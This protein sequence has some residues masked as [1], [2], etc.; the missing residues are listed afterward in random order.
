MEWRR[1]RTRGGDPMSTPIPDPQPRPDHRREA[2][3]TP[4]GAAPRTDKYIRVGT[5]SK[6]EVGW[7]ERLR[8]ARVGVALVTRSRLMSHVRHDA[9]H[10]GTVTRSRTTSLSTTH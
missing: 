5:V 10:T 7:A 3:S 1:S 9:P 2:R 4:T 6:V 8:H